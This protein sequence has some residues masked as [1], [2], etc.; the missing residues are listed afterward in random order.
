MPICLGIVHLFSCYNG[1]IWIIV[2]D[3]ALLQT[4]NIYYLGFI[5]K[6]ANTCVMW[7][8]FGSLVE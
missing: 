1:K 8:Y 5:E 6:I 2:K 7:L 4:S 3:I